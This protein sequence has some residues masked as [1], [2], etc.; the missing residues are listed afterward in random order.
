[1]LNANNM[2][3]CHNPTV[4]KLQSRL[5]SWLSHFDE[6]KFKPSFQ[7]SLNQLYSCGK[8]EKTALY[9]LL[10]SLFYSDEIFLKKTRNNNLNILNNAISR[11]TQFS[12]HGDVNFIVLNNLNYT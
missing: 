9:F 3:G 1:M 10:I 7:D 8:K 11:I 4:V 6:N 12:L 5:R 2:F